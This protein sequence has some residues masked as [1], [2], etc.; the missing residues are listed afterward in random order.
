MISFDLRCAGNHV[1]EIWFRSSADY[2]SQRAAG[3][4]MCPVCGDDDVAKAVMAPAVSAK[5]NRQRQ[6]ASAPADHYM[7]D[8]KTAPDTGQIRA[9]MHALA[10]A[11]AEALKESRWVGDKFA[12]RARAMY[13]GEE[14]NAAIH[15][16]ANLHEA[17]AM[18]EEGLA[19]A[20]LLVPIVPPDQTN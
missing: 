5:G 14:E 1:F 6:P 3:Q 19:V 10:Q 16:T 11:Q 17:R 15:G 8:G 13:H 7:A 18:L 4:I 9:L 12:D 2:D 20:P